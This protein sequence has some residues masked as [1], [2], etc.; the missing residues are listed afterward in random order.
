MIKTPGK[1]IIHRRLAKFILSEIGSKATEAS[2]NINLCA[3]LVSDIEGAVH[4][5]L[6][7]YSRFQ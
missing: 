1:G 7:Y 6:Y 2:V 4:G 3:G 5:T